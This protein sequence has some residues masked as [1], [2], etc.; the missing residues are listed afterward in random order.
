MIPISSL[1]FGLHL[2]DRKARP[3]AADGGQSYRPNAL[4]NTDCVCVTPLNL[5][6]KF[7]TTDVS[8]KIT[9]HRL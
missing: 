8:L 9:R 6:V 1:V 4:R 3:S 7:G 2:R 5:D